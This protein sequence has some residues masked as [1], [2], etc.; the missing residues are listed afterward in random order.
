MAT[1]TPATVETVAE[2]AH[3]T[4]KTFFTEMPSDCATCWLKAVARIASPY[5]EALKNQAIPPI[6][7]IETTKLIR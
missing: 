6:I 2:I 3:A 7:A 5:F 1:T 4:A